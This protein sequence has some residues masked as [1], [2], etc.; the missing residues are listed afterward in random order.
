MVS[1]AVN[2]VCA[3]TDAEELELDLTQLGIG[4]LDISFNRK[5][6]LVSGSLQHASVQELTVTDN[7]VLQAFEVRITLHA[8]HQCLGLCTAHPWS[9]KPS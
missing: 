1:G 9:F 5:L 2:V 3:A 7:A 4:H 6:R 8:R